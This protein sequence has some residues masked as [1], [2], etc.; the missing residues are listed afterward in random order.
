VDLYVVLSGF[1]VLVISM[2]YILAIWV[3][4]VK[5]ENK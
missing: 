5:A 2:L 3:Y 4:T 1:F